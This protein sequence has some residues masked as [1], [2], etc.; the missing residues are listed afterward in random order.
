[1]LALAVLAS[2]ACSRGAPPAP[3]ATPATT[4]PDAAEE[5]SSP[6][7]AAADAPAPPIDGA[8]SGGTSGYHTRRLIACTITDVEDGGVVVSFECERAVKARWKGDL[9]NEDRDEP[10][11]G[12][13]FD[14]V[15][16]SPPERVRAV[17]RLP[18]P[19]ADYGN[20]KTVRIVE[21]YD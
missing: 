7:D 6:I 9:W 17:A 4:P 11:K 20:V 5:E 18:R 15:G 19:L 2:C 21:Q 13:R 1:M 3:I 12:S 8:T 10:I 16:S 14:V